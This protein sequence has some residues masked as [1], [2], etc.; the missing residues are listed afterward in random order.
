MLLIDYIFFL[1]VT[2]YRYRDIPKYGIIPIIYLA[3]ALPHGYITGDFVY[4]FFDISE[5]GVLGFAGYMFGML[6]GYLS[7]ALLFSYVKNKFDRTA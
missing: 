7:F 5:V 3:Y 4:F 6:V 2:D 1:D